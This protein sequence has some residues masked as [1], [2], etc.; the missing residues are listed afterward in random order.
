MTVQRKVPVSRMNAH[1]AAPVIMTL[2]A[3]AMRRSPEQQLSTGGRRSQVDPNGI[4]HRPCQRVETA[5]AAR[6]TR[7]ARL[8]G[9][10]EAFVSCPHIDAPFAGRDGAK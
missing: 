10:R 2:S 3:L 1:G 5:E 4:R 8:E 7:T 6:G 9:T